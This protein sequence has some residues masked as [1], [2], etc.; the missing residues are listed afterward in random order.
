MAPTRHFPGRGV[1]PQL[2]QDAR[3]PPGRGR[4]PT[5]APFG[6]NGFLSHSPCGAHPA[7]AQ[8]R[9]A[10]HG[11]PHPA[12]SQAPHQPPCYTNQGRRT[13]W[14]PLPQTPCSQGALTPGTPRSYRRCRGCRKTPVGHSMRFA[15]CPQQGQCDLFSQVTCLPNWTILLLFFSSISQP[16]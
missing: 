16:L 2:P 3:L 11:A 7:G 9:G 5:A 14:G 8:A 15:S 13:R 1:S 6:G 10:A 12:V 4:H